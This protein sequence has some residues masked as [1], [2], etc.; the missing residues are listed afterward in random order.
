M[1][2]G[3]VDFI[4]VDRIG[5][6]AFSKGTDKPVTVRVLRGSEVIAEA[7]ASVERPDVQKVHGITE[8]GFSLSSEKLKKLSHEELGDVDIFAIDSVGAQIKLPWSQ[9]N[10]E[11]F[12]K[13]EK[14][15]TG[16]YQSHDS[17]KSASNSSGKLDAIKLPDLKGKR[18]LDIGCNEGFF[19]G[20][21]LRQGATRVVGMDKGKKFIEAAR[22]IYPEAEFFEQSWDTLP[23]EQFD[24]II[25]L[26]ALHYEKSPRDLMKRIYDRLAPGGVFVLEYGCIMGGQQK[27]WV[28]VPRGVGVVKYPT[29]PLLRDHILEDFALRVVGRSVDQPGDPQP[30]YVF[31]CKRKKTN[32]IIAS[33]APNTGKTNLGIDLGHAG[34]AN[35]RIDQLLIEQS[36][37]AVKLADKTLDAY[38]RTMDHNKINVWVDSI[39][40]IDMAGRLALFLANALPNECDVVYAEGY[41][42]SNPFVLAEFKK[43]MEG[44][45][46]R[47]WHTQMLT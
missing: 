15:A 34:V 14:V 23:N 11:L 9:K 24:V 31:H 39:K 33:G 35:V 25:M 36:R 27:Y 17:G 30:R 44:R 43:V 2:R 29:L 18:F 22:K 6:W 4:S 37:R 21:A 42:F 12:R 47:V 45:D 46:A 38:I 13:K 8:C 28:E 26:S 7:S 19:C 40:E 3:Y 5:G 41:V 1:L 20:E 16:G 10:V 32:Y